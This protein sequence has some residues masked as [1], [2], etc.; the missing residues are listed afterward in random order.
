MSTITVTLEYHDPDPNDEELYVVRK[1]VAFTLDDTEAFAADD[2][3]VIGQPAKEKIEQ[4][5]LNFPKPAVVWVS[6]A[7]CDETYSLEN[8]MIRHYVKKEL[9]G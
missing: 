9:E 5:V 1:E 4:E 2:Y 7:G 8:V 3:P 6:V